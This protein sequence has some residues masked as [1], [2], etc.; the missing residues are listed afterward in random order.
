MTA[1]WLLPEWLRPASSESDGREPEMAHPT[2]VSDPYDASSTWSYAKYQQELT[3]RELLDSEP[4]PILPTVPVPDV[5]ETTVVPPTAA[6]LRQQR[7]ATERAAR[8]EAERR[9]HKRRQDLLD[10]LEP[11]LRTLLL[12]KLKLGDEIVLTLARSRVCTMR[13]LSILDRDAFIQFLIEEFGIAALDPAASTRIDEVMSRTMLEARRML[14]QMT[15]A[16]TV[17]PSERPV[18]EA[19]SLT[20][21][22]EH[23]AKRQA[24]QA[25]TRKALAAATDQWRDY[26]TLSEPALDERLA[27]DETSAPTWKEAA[28]WAHWL[29]RRRMASAR[30]SDSPRTWRSKGAIEQCLRHA[31][32]HIFC[33]LYPAMRR[34]TRGERRLYWARVEQSFAMLFTNKGRQRW[35]EQAESN[36]RAAAVRNGK[37]RSEQDAAAT[38]AVQVITAVLHQ[39]PTRSVSPERSPSPPVVEPAERRRLGLDG[40]L[41]REQM[42]AQRAQQRKRNALSRE[43]WMMQV[44]GKAM[45]TQQQETQPGDTSATVQVPNEDAAIAIGRLLIKLQAPPGEDEE[46]LAGDPAQAPTPAAAS[47]AI[48]AEELQRGNEG[49]PDAIA[50]SAEHAAAEARGG[51]VKVIAKPIVIVAEPKPIVVVWDSKRRRDRRLRDSRDSRDSHPQTPSSAHSPGSPGARGGRSSCGAQSETPPAEPTTPVAGSSPGSLVEQSPAWR[52]GKRPP[53]ASSVTVVAQSAER[54]RAL[55]GGGAMSRRV[56]REMPSSRSSTGEHKPRSQ[57]CSREEAGAVKKPHA[58]P[59]QSDSDSD[60]DNGFIPVKVVSGGA[61]AAVKALATWTCAELAKAV[62]NLLVAENLLKTRPSSIRRE[63]EEK[64]TVMFETAGLTGLAVSKLNS[65]ELEKELKQHTL[66]QSWV[67]DVLK[68]INGMMAQQPS[69]SESPTRAARHSRESS[70]NRTSREGSPTRTSYEGSPTQPPEAPQALSEEQEAAE[71]A[72]VEATLATVEA[73][74]APPPAPEPIS[75]P[76]PMETVA[77]EPSEPELDV[78]ALTPAPAQPQ[79]APVVVVAKRILPAQDGIHREM[80]AQ[81]ALRSNPGA[82]RVP[83]AALHASDSIKQWI[84]AEDRGG[85]ETGSKPDASRRRAPPSAKGGARLSTRK[86]VKLKA[87]AP[88]QSARPRP[89]LYS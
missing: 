67:G 65:T 22:I 34:L 77:E 69:K 62:C 28:S 14:A 88:S 12:D 86:P 52:G 2:P 54:P 20:A 85:A 72:P 75:A 48:I 26:L 57:R 23:E 30:V 59:D 7:E 46:S 24:S 10:S 40:F 79:A 11:P 74:S 64:L 33:A 16:R 44:Q 58:L 82:G 32:E 73:T 15:V 42:A 87:R 61:G 25:L 70:P 21:K 41:S 76:P 9:S 84:Q 81:Y 55:T 56:S 27:V 38:Q 45:G 4:S 68:V 35:K 5:A 80:L 49:D 50:Q 53:S 63:R 31:K 13:D 19:S 51:F 36:A 29:L 89:A 8:D 17:L 78:L 60:S 37:S 66:G 18:S 47:A 6:E 39:S 71:P 83:I 1:S 43:K 3:R